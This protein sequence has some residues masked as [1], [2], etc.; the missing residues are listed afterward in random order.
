MRLRRRDFITLLGG[1]VAWPI[2]ARAQQAP[3]ATVGILQAGPPGSLA[4][5]APPFRK[6]LSEMGYVEGRNL[7]LEYRY[8]QNELERVPELAADLIRRR[9]AVLVTLGSDAVAAAAKT[10]TATTPV[11]FEIGGDPVESG[12][13]TS[14][15]RPGGNLTGVTSMNAELTAKRAGLLH[16]LL[17]QARRMATILSDSPSSGPIAKSLQAAASRIGV[18]VE[19]LHASTGPEIDTAFAGLVQARVDALVVT[20]GPPFSDHYAQIATLAARHAIP[21]IYPARSAANVGGLMSYA[22]SPDRVRQ[23]GIYVG[24][25]LKGEK[26]GDLP[27][28]LP[29]KFDF[30]INLQTARALGIEVP[31]T[32]LSIADEII[33]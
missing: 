25:I 10:A 12:L 26:P 2:A 17:P 1:A 16:D 28:I 8:A 21:A 7:T 9:V 4:D 24:R 29:T 27:V 30:V 31:P 5:F 33:E 32:L 11:V 15:N 22:T 20:A 18:E 3:M 14:L 19:L 6:G 13:V 23:V